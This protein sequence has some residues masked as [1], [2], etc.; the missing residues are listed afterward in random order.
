MVLSA[1][2]LAFLVLLPLLLGAAGLRA[3]GLGFQSDPVGH[4][5]WSW[6]VGSLFLAA[7]ELLRLLS[8][9][10]SPGPLAATG[11]LLAGV[12]LVLGRRNRPRTLSAHA[13]EARPGRLFF[14][15]VLAL[16]L[17]V[18][19]LRAIEAN[20]SAI[21]RDDEALFW[22]KR[23]KLW[24]EARGFGGV[25]ARALATKR[26]PNP[27]YPLLNPLL[28]L[29]CFDLAGRITHVV[30]RVPLQLCSLALVLCTASAL[31]RAAGPW[32]AGALLILLVSSA[33]AVS[34]VGSASSDVL[35]ALG[36][37][38]AL[39][40]F[41]RGESER[42]RAWFALAGLAAAFLLWSKHEGLLIV[43]AFSAAYASVHRRRARELFSPRRAHLACLP[44]ACVLAITW[45]HN[46]CFATATN[47]APWVG[48]FPGLATDLGR[49]LAHTLEA[50][51]RVCFGPSMN[52]V[53]AAFLLLALLAPVARR[54]RL[55]VVTL[56]LVLILLGLVVVYVAKE[57]DPSQL[58]GN[59]LGRV[60]FHL[61]PPVLVWIACVADA[62]GAGRPELAGAVPRPG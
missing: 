47:H 52:Y 33:P 37:V 29:W 45:I 39:D 23:A 60:L 24:F 54:G 55:A 41:L 12:L 14:Q 61:E 2:Q 57:S 35:V 58:L 28:Q 34:A 10:G 9:L 59:T 31:R 56:S 4:L 1:L 36:S 43:A 48:A 21:V 38:V 62:L 19:A 51:A 46:A 15:C 32:L 20:W 18:T 11:L 5:G 25:Y 42:E 6:M 49:D 3:L 13:S 26:F 17:A 53:F 27:D 22:S 8:G 7:L 50:F 40:A 30:N 16:A 44:A